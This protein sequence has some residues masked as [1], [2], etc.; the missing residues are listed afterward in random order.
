MAPAPAV[1]VRTLSPTEK[2]ATLLMTMPK[3]CAAT[4]MKHMEQGF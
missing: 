1:R 4:V 2:V 3:D